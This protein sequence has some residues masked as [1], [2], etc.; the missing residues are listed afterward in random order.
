MVRKTSI[1]VFKQIEAEGL[2]SK[3]R[4][5]VYSALFEFGP[6]TA[7]ELYDRCFSKT[8]RDHSI[9]PRFSELERLGV[10]QPLKERSCNVSGRNVMVWDVTDRLPLKLDKPKKRKCHACNGRGYHQEE[11]VRM[12]V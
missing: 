3:L 8:S 6:C 9:T 12:D 11:Q 4:F 10:I 2:L 7:L 1:E 5:D